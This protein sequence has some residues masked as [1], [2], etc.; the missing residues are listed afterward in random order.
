M[1]AGDPRRATVRVANSLRQ[2]GRDSA[3]GISR[4]L[5]RQTD[6]RGAAWS[7]EALHLAA[8]STATAVSVFRVL[9]EDQ[10][11]P[12][13]FPAEVRRTVQAVA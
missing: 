10:P 7:Q 2:G 1:A 3:D 12:R 9:R 13:F 11:F 8:S 4:I 6:S 5:L